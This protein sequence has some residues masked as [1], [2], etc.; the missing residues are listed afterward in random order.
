MLRRQLFTAVLAFIIA[1]VWFGGAQAQ[2]AG[3]ELAAENEQLQL[4][5]NEN[6]TEIAVLVVDRPCLVFES[7]R[8]PNYG[9]HG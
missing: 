4:Y 1:A 3:F 9:D 6:T 7:S 8:P 5:F 2:L